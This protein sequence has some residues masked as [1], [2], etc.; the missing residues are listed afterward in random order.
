MPQY[1]EIIDDH[2]Y[3]QFEDML[4]AVT[5]SHAMLNYLNLRGSRSTGPN[6]NYAR[7]VMELHTI[8]PVDTYDE[9]QIYPVARVLTGYQY[10]S[11]WN[12]SALPEDEEEFLQ[13]RFN[14][15]SVLHDMLPKQVQLANTVQW[16][17]AQD[18]I[19]STPENSVCGD[20]EATA[21]ENEVFVFMCLLAR[22]PKSAE[23]VGKKL[24]KRFLGEDAPIDEVLPVFQLAWANSNA[25]LRRALT[26]L[27]TARPGTE[28]YG[29]YLLRSLFLEQPVV[30]RPLEYSA[31]MVRALRVGIE[32]APYSTSYN[33][34][35][36]DLIN[37]G[38]DSYRVG[39]PT[40]YPEEG[41]A[42]LGNSSVLIKLNQIDWV[43]DTIGTP[44]SYLMVKPTVLDGFNDDLG[45][46]NSVVNHVIP[47][48][49]IS[50]EQEQ[51]LLEY[52]QFNLAH[53]NAK[54][55]YHQNIKALDLLKL[56]LALPQVA[57]H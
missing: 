4:M 53:Y 11:F 52:M 43:I 3:G 27:L 36:S 57:Y 18:G 9:A 35:K 19:N 29:S 7:E 26:A 41:K 13:V 16:K 2:K 39:P 6:E 17:F 28:E 37:S 1:Q 32:G 45:L 42:W 30:K 25:N 38:E 34:F 23:L 31:S 22:H 56:I 48:G 49:K 12:L 10:T 51:A 44:L 40:G 5:K 14:S 8:G 20:V 50:V 21:G 55:Y 33:K 47:S 46:I 24:I 54:S 15:G